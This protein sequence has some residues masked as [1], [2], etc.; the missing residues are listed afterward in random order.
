MEVA[1]VLLFI[2]G[3]AGAVL[4]V[5]PGPL[6]TAGALVLI[7]TNQ[8]PIEGMNL[9]VWASL[10]LIVFVADYFMPSIFTKLGGGSKAAS[11]G[12]LIGLIAGIITPFFILA[13]FVGAM[14][15]ELLQTRD[16]L[17]SLKAAFFAVI[18]L[19]TGMVMKLAYCVA[20]P[21]VYCY[22]LFG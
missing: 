3:L 17:K 15:G 7:L 4:P 18:G 16:V 8:G 22:N 21:L 9:T 6:L 1:I 13:A 10:G 19:F 12:A 2:A 14:L 5:L 20:A 11:R